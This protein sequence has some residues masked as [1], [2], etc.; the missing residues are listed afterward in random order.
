MDVGFLHHRAVT[1]LW[2][3]VARNLLEA[4][5]LPMD[6]DWY[7]TYLDE[8]VAGI[9]L[10]YGA[11]LE[12]NNA[13]MKYFQQAVVRFGNATRHFLDVTLANLDTNEYVE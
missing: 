10:R 9:Q 1:Q 11:Q 3:E 12:A 6:L 4:D 8:Q 5:V 2:T 7:A 13:T